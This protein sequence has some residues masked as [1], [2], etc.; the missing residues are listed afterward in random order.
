MIFIKR[1]YFKSIWFLFLKRTV[2]I[3]TQKSLVKVC[4]G[5]SGGVVFVVCVPII[6]RG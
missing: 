4:S 1:D 2:N 5:L 6:D 3:L